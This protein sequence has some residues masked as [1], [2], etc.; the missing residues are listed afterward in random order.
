MRAVN[1]HEILPLE[2]SGKFTEWH[3]RAH[4]SEL[5][6]H[7]HADGVFTSDFLGGKLCQKEARCDHSDEL[8]SFSVMAL[9]RELVITRLFYLLN[10]VLA[11]HIVWNESRWLQVEVLDGVFL[12]PS[13]VWNKLWHIRLHALLFSDQIVFI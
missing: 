13:I 3:S 5:F 6:G 11:G 1:K 9:N 12:A 10:G 8:T 4:I 7:S 2:D